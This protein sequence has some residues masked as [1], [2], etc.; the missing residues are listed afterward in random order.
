MLIAL[1]MLLAIHHHSYDCLLLAVPWIGLT[2]FGETVAASTGVRTRWLAVVLTAVP[3]VNYLSTISFQE[4]FDL[5]RN[6]LAWQVITQINGVCLLLALVI[7]ATGM[8]RR[9]Q[10]L[11]GKDTC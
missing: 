6:G 7:L 9:R 5:D 10:P 8:G 1:S 3:A 4:K 2:L 11:D